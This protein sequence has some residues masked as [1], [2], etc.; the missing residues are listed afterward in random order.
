MEYQVI[1]NPEN[2]QFEAKSD[3]KEV[4]GLID[5]TLK[6]KTMFVTHTEV[7]PEYEGMGIAGK[8]TKYMLDYAKSND[9]KIAPICPYTKTYIERHNEYQD[10]LAES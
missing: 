9:L 6:E 10:L 8:M 1:H 7:K 4:I 3:S 5:Y 2:S